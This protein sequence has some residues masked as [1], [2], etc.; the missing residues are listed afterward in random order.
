VH[1]ADGSDAVSGW[2]VRFTEQTNTPHIV[3]V[4]DLCEHEPANCWCQPTLDFDQWVHHAA[5]EREKSEPDRRLP[6]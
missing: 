6:S 1:D 4:D 5:D 3:P 2:R